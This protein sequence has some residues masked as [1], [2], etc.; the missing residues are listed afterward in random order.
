MAQ[1]KGIL[2]ARIVRA[3]VRALSPFDGAQE[4]RNLFGDV[5]PCVSRSPARSGERRPDRD[6]TKVTPEEDESR[7]KEEERKD[8]VGERGR[9]SKEGE[10]SLEGA[11]SVRD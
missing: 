1:S 7:R 5:W 9:G 11:R 6:E 2:R 10:E 8:V 3:D 4:N